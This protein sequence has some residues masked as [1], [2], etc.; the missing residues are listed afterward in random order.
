MFARIW[1]QRL[2]GGDFLADFRHFGRGP[3]HGFPHFID[4]RRH[5]VNR[6]DEPRQVSAKRLEFLVAAH[7]VPID[8]HGFK[9]PPSQTQPVSGND[10][11]LRDARESLQTFSVIVA[12]SLP[13][14]SNCELTGRSFPAVYARLT[15]LYRHN[16]PDR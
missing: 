14:L 3:L 16:S 8:T 11:Q 4:V 1:P 7:V 13:S 9:S 12:E 10:A 5:G 15:R 2:Q 6:R